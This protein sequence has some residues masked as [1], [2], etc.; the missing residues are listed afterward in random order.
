MLGTC[1]LCKMVNVKLQNSHLMPSAFYRHMLREHGAP[2]SASPN[3]AL[4]TSKQ[5]KTHLLCT[6]CEERFNRRGENWTLRN[7]CRKSGDFP[8][9]EA[10]LKQTPSA[11]YGT[12]PYY[13]A[14]LINRI[15]ID[16]LI[17]FALSV[18]WRASAHEWRFVD[19]SYKLQLEE[20][21]EQIRQYLLDQASIPDNMVLPI[22][23]SPSTSP[24]NGVMFPHTFQHSPY[25]GHGFS[26]PGMVFSLLIGDAIPD[27]VKAQCAFHRR[28]VGLTRIADQVALE[29]KESLASLPASA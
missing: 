2:I 23:I 20:H 19:C 29:A 17:Y 9:Q 8:I 15:D 24:Q 7:Y 5:I 18:F 6:A 4:Q 16:K 25:C 27:D 21:E 28:L 12:I 13:R 3:I 10:M 11:L 14:G 1:R 22:I 26:I